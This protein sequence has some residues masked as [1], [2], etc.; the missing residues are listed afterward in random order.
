MK[1]NSHTN[2]PII[3][4][5]LHLE[6]LNDGESLIEAYQMIKNTWYG[7][8]GIPMLDYSSQQ[9]GARNGKHT[10]HLNQEHFSNFINIM[11]GIFFCLRIGHALL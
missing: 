11:K 8:H 7:E 9:E 4:D 10:N 3:L 1:I 5:N 2:I 6:C